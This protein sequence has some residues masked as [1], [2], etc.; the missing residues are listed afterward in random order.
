MN[1]PQQGSCWRDVAAVS[2]H[3]GT[4]EAAKGLQVCSGN[5]R[6]VLKGKDTAFEQF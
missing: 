6:V 1:T 5:Y 4:Q 2:N 3:Q